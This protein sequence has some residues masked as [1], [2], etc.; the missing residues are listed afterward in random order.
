[1]GAEQI[2]QEIIDRVA[3]LLTARQQAH[4]HPVWKMRLPPPIPRESIT[5]RPDLGAMHYRVPIYAG[6]DVMKKE[7]VGSA[8][9]KV[10]EIRSGIVVPNPY[11][12]RLFT[13]ADAYPIKGWLHRSVAQEMPEGWLFDYR[14]AEPALVALW[15]DAADDAGARKLLSDQIAVWVQDTW[16]HFASGLMTVG[17]VPHQNGFI[18]CGSGSE[19]WTVRIECPEDQKSTFTEGQLLDRIA[20]DMVLPEDDTSR[21]PGV[22]WVLVQYPDDPTEMLREKLGDG[23]SVMLLDYQQR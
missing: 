8:A 5:M 13:W 2:Y 6:R 3:W 20:V 15:R 1:M 7:I 21:H 22:T 10:C 4:Q 9:F 18:D 14:I 23:W 11:G 19:L 12:H 16:M 17:L